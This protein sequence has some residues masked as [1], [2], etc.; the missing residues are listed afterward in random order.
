ME[1]R[2]K[3]AGQMKEAF[4]EKVGWVLLVVLDGVQQNQQCQL[5]SSVGE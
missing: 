1:R 2:F 4:A 3:V 5:V